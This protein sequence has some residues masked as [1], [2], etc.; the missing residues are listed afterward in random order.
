LEKLYIYQGFWQVA[1]ELKKQF[2]IDAIPIYLK[3]ISFLKQGSKKVFDD[4]LIEFGIPLDGKK[5]VEIYRN[6]S[7]NLHLFPDVEESLHDFRNQ[8]HSL[9]LL[10]NGDS[11]TQWNKVNALKLKFL[12]HLI[13]VPADFGKDYWKPSLKSMEIIERKFSGNRENFLFIGNGKDDLQFAQNAGIEFV[14][15]K[16]KHRLKSI[17]VKT[18]NG[19]VIENLFQLKDL[20]D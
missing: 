5:M 17:N 11:Q 8:G 3:L 15:L 14:F 19:K 1:G 4:M 6:S 16:R 10:T 18:F 2:Q 12:F 13:V 20:I 9:I 7:R